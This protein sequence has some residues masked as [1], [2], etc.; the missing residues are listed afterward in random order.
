VQ[1]DLRVVP[2]DSF[3]AALQ[4]FT[5][6]KDHNIH[7]RS[8][9]R[10]RGLKINEYG[11]FRGEERVAGATEDEVYA[12]LGMA[13]MPPEI[14]ENRGEI[15]AA[16]RQALPRLVAREDLRGELHVHLPAEDKAAPDL[17]AWRAAA[18]RRAY[19]YLGFVVAPPDEEGD[20]S[21]VAKALRAGAGE[22]S[23]SVGVET[24]VG[25]ETYVGGDRPMPDHPAP[26]FDFWVARPAPPSGS[27]PLAAPP[28]ELPD[29]HPP[30][31]VAHLARARDAPDAKPSY[32]ERFAAWLK[33]ARDAESALEVTP[34][35]SEDG[36]DS[37]GVRHAT[38]QGL[39][40]LLTARP[41]RPEELERTEIPLGLARRG[42][43]EPSRVLNAEERPGAVPPRPKERPAARSPTP[44]RRRAR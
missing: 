42:W 31:F 17:A 8:I 26:G 1:I 18:T 10:D 15:E 23:D 34:F 33:W 5:G 39:R 43:A 3:G 35:G 9:A 11:V 41:E 22:R 14:R 7:L 38:G 13:A 32:A 28:K 44:R 27:E 2:P 29:A 12:T 25:L 40:V 16:Q 6:S 19:R 21:E 24:W 30:L 20:P 36:L 37:G 4:Y